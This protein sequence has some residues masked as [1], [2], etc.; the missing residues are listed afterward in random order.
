MEDLDFYLERDEL[1]FSVNEISDEKQVQIFLNVVESV[2]YSLLCCPLAP[3]NP[4][5]KSLIELMQALWSHFQTKRNVI[6]KRFRFPRHIQM[7]SE[8]VAQFVA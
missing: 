7:A 5:D 3:V 2:T 6:A 4:K 1:Y 8:S